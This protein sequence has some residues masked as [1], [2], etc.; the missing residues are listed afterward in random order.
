MSSFQRVVQASIDLDIYTMCSTIHFSPS[1]SSSE[2]GRTKTKL[3]VDGRCRLLLIRE[4]TGGPSRQ[5]ALW[6]DVIMYVFSYASSESLK[7]VSC[8]GREGW[9]GGRGKGRCGNRRL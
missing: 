4:E 1:L 9:L 7:E 8:V 5:V 6:A 2:D 3:T